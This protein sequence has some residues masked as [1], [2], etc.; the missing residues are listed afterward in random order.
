MAEAFGLASSAI[1]IAAIF[2]TAVHCF[3]YIQLGRNFDKDF[4]TSLL[5]LNLLKLRLT[6]WGE[7]VNIHNDPQLG[8]PT[9]T[10]D[11]IGMAKSALFQVLILFADSEKTANKFRP[12]LESKELAVYSDK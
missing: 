6:R 3:E 10:P 7:A 1:G 8:Q 4:Q 5:T 9:A 12:M 2:T 11:T